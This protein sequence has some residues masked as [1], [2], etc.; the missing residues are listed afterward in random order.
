MFAAGWETAWH[1]LQAEGCDAR[2]GWKAP[3]CH[4]VE[5]I[6]VLAPF[7]SAVAWQSLQ[8]WKVSWLEPCC[9]A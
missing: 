4:R 8:F 1:A 7:E 2:L 6:G 3:G 5:T 9:I